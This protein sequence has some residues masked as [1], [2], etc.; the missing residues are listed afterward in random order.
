MDQNP[1]W[2]A[3]SHSASQ[4]IP[5]HLWYPKVHYRVHKSLCNRNKM[6]F[7]AEVLLAPRPIPKLQDHLLSVVRHCTILAAYFQI[8]PQIEESQYLG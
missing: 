8:H 2:E 5:R 3:N 7:Y 6:V 4:E 1:S